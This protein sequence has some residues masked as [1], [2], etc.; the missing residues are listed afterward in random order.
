MTVRSPEPSDVLP[1]QLSPPEIDELLGARLIAN[2]ASI[3]PNGTVHLVAMWFR[4]DG[5]SIFFPTSHHTRKAKS[6]DPIDDISGT[7]GL[8]AACDSYTVMRYHDSGAV[9]HVGGRLWDRDVDKFELRRA[10]QR[11]EL[12]GEY[13]GLTDAL[14]GTLEAL[15]AARA[16]RETFRRRMLPFL[17]VIL[18]G[19]AYVS[20]RQSPHL[21]MHGKSIALSVGLVGFVAG[22]FD[23]VLPDL[24]S[25]RMDPALAS[26]APPPPLPFA[27]YVGSV[28]LYGLVYTS[29]VLLLGLIL[30][31]DRDLA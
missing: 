20:A 13:T 16:S 17:V 15:R 30:F 11:W 19:V 21:G 18:G 28:T 2:L 8:T 3:N 10:K 5:D 6:D 25:F 9:L 22:V 1:L 12:V 26:D 4:R 14:T 31:E 29:I 27:Q 23:T 24:G 7:Y